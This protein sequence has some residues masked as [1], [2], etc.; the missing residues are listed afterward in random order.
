MRLKPALQ[1]SFALGQISIKIQNR[2]Y[3]LSCDDGEEDRLTE[4]AGHVRAKADQLIAEHGRIGD[5]H[6]MLMSAILIADELWDEREKKPVSA[7]R[8]ADMSS[9]GKAGS[10]PTAP[11]KARD[12]TPESAA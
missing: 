2:T 7:A 5:E 10:Q 11:R 1:E 9:S 4:L 8:H 6:L 12:K 3:R